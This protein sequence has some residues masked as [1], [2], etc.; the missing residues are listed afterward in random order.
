MTRRR[1]TADTAAA[2]VFVAPVVRPVPRSAPEP[3]SFA[4]VW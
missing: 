1:P 2:H 3:A 4:S